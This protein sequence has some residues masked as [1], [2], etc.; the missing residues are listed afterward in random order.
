MRADKKIRER[1]LWRIGRVLLATVFQIGGVSLGATEAGGGG[2]VENG[3]TESFE[4]FRDGIGFAVA[5]AKLGED[6]WIDRDSIAQQAAADAPG[7][8]FVQA[9][10]GIESVD[11]HIGIEKDHGSR[12]RVRSFSQLIIGVKAAE[13][14][15]ESTS[16]GLGLFFLGAGMTLASS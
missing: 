7:S 11:Q 15:K 10:G 2:K 13:A 4:T 9:G 3:D 12:V 5:D 8:P 1:G 14:N 16:V 6:H